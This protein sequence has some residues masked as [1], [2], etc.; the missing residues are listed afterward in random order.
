MTA[1]NRQKSNAKENK[2]SVYAK[3]ISFQAMTGKYLV[4]LLKIIRNL[5]IGGKQN[6]FSDQ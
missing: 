6:I 1:Q 2:K 3:D 4:C 5:T